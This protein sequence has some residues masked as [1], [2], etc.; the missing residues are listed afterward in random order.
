MGEQ[1]CCKLEEA[2]QEYTLSIFQNG[3]VISVKGNIISRV[4]TVEN[5]SESCLL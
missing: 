1:S 4:Q 5:R 2:E 3:E